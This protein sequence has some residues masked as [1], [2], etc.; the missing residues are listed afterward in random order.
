MTCRSR[1]EGGLG[2]TRA[3]IHHLAAKETVGAHLLS[4]HNIHYML[5][6][7]GQARAA[8][9]ED[10]YPEF[11]REFFSKL[12]SQREDFPSWAVNALKGVG[13]EL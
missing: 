2:I 7:M 13:V 10:R 11:I 9:L 6:L 8:I 3:Y 5:Q 12:Y 4:M 1:E